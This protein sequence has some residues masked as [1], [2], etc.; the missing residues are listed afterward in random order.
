M[1]TTY[2]APTIRVVQFMVE[3]GYSSSGELQMID[4]TAI[5]N[6]HATSNESGSHFRNES[7]GG[8]TFGDDYNFFGN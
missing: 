2:I 8:S 5:I 7:F 4:G 1:K 6:F 3:Q